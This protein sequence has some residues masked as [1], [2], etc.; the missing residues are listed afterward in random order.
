MAIRQL[1]LKNVRAF[2]DTGILSTGDVVAIVGQ[3]DAGKSAILH[4][5]QYFFEPPKK[6]GAPLQDIHGSSPNTE[7]AVEVAFDPRRLR[8]TNV[9]IDAKNIVELS[10]ENLLDAEGLLRLRRRL[11]DK[12]TRPLEMKIFDFDDPELFGIAILKKQDELISLLEKAGLQATPAG[13]ETNAEKRKSLRNCCSTSKKEDW[14]ELSDK[15]KAIQE[16]LPQFRFF[17]DDARFGVGETPVQ[18]QFKGVID[19]ALKGLSIAE[20]VKAQA[21]K[22]LQEEFNKVFEHLSLLTSAVKGINAQTN[23]DW[24]KAVSGIGLSWMD[25]F[26]VSVPYELRGAGIRRLFMVSYFEYEA[27]EGLLEANG[28]KYIFCIEEPEIHLHPGAQRVLIEAIQQLSEIGHMCI[29]TTHSPVFASMVPSDSLILVSRKGVSA[30]ADQ[31]PNIDLSDVAA[32]LGVEAPDRLIGKNYVV[33][34]EGKSDAEFFQEALRI[35]YDN[36]HTSLNPSSVCFLQCGGI[37]NLRYIVTTKKMDE[38]GLKWA[39]IVDS[40]R[41]QSGESTCNKLEMCKSSA[42]PTCK[43]F[44]ILERTSL[45]NYFDRNSIR[46]VTGFDIEV[47]HFGQ[48]KDKDGKEVGDKDKKVIKNSAKSICSKMGCTGL[49]ECSTPNGTQ[50]PTESELVKIFENIRISFELSS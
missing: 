10:E 50:N 15:E 49:V 21:D 19:R 39:V 18:N 7:M 12:S 43:S 14:I 11:D 46:E 30:S 37:G 35:L 1:R 32:E 41:S 2:S 17:T 31:F 4:G 26:G 36:N 24:K 27:A 42:L 8:S 6:G 22:T 45:E 40:D 25:E 28:P 34:V 48:L 16:I 5:L 23:L 33:L 47:P 44:N 29:F 20:D 9:K 13:K 38:V 3:N